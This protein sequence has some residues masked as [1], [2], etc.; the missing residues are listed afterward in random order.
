MLGVALPLLPNVE[1]FE[2][3]CDIAEDCFGMLIRYLSS[4]RQAVFNETVFETIVRTAVTG[5]GV[6]NYET[7]KVLY[8][9]L[10]RLMDFSADYSLD[11]NS[12]VGTI[13]QK[14]YPELVKSAFL[15]I[16][17]VPPDSIFDNLNELLVYVFRANHLGKEWL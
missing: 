17:N 11:H 1:A 12:Y 3:K 2:Q 13:V 9:F 5:V 10:E 16:L 6:N 4:Y 14:Y 15:A 7:G 8:S